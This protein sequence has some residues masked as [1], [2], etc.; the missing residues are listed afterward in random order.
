MAQEKKYRPIR[1]S[2]PSSNPGGGEYDPQVTNI[3]DILRKLSSDLADLSGSPMVVTQGTDPWLIS[4]TVNQGT[5]PWIVSGNATISGDVGIN[6]GFLSTLNSTSTP[7]ASGGT[8]VGTWEDV[9]AYNSISVAAKA[10]SNSAATG[11]R[12]E[13]SPDAGV[14]SFGAVGQALLANGA[15]TMS[16]PVNMKYARVTY[17]NGPTG[18][19]T[20]V[21]QTI[22]HSIQQQLFL[23]IA[24][25][26]LGVGG[27][28]MALRRANINATGSTNT[29]IAGVSGLIYRVVSIVLCS[30]VNQRVSFYSN[31]TPIVEEITLGPRQPFIADFAPGGLLF[32]TQIN[33]PFIIKTLD[34]PLGRL[35]GFVNYIQR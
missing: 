25:G 14:T 29:I 11:V 7:L 31:V 23:P 20:F 12:V 26:S 21:I 35:S 6:G 32:E 10:S 18:Q 28:Q 3:Y 9:S 2:L 34:M 5:N 24:N 33:Q 16:V 22:Y 27:V 30:T 8:F 15:V 1:I 4:G 19:T 13:Q 17:I